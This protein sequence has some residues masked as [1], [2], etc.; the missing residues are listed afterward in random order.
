MGV[1]SKSQCIFCG[2]TPTTETH[3][4]RKGWFQTAI[5][6]GLKLLGHRHVRHEAE[7]FDKEWWAPTTAFAPYAACPKCNGGW[8]NDLDHA[9]EKLFLTA[10]ALGRPTGSLDPLGRQVV[11]HWAS[12]VAALFDQCQNPPRLTADH[13]RTIHRGSPPRGTRV[14]VAA[15]SP[16][17][18]AM[19]AEVKAQ[20]IAHPLDDEPDGDRAPGFFLTVRIRSLIM[21]ILVP[22]DEQAERFRFSRANTPEGLVE[23]WPEVTGPLYWPPQLLTFEE[24]GDLPYRFSILAL[25]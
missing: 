6:P 25:R 20:D 5:A 23:L 22:L 17:P 13:H 24:L 12:V 10:A 2:K 15:T 16:P 21:Q 1:A 3:I 14:W 7:P 18:G 19:P 9:A 4:L 8:M 11:A